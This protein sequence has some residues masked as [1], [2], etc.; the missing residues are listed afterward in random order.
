MLHAMGGDNF[1]ALLNQTL[2]EAMLS[3][4][5]SQTFINDIITPISRVNYGQSVRLHAFV[6]MS[7]QTIQLLHVRLGI[8]QG[9]ISV[10]VAVLVISAVIFAYICRFL[11]LSV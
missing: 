6:G 2:E 8:R 1:L 7:A 3:Q 5:F 9:L 11:L 4:G 10:S